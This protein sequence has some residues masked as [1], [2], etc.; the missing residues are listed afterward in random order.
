MTNL[1]FKV[2]ICGSLG[3]REGN[4]CRRAARR[5]GEAHFWGDVAAG[6]R[7]RKHPVV[8]L[9]GGSEFMHRCVRLRDDFMSGAYLSAVLFAAD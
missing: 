9:L 4:P 5:E 2:A 3:V 6:C 1:V 8:L 7:W